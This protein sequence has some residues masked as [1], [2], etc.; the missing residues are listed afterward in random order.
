MLVRFRFGI[1]TRVYHVND[2][3][4]HV[5]PGIMFNHRQS[6]RQSISIDPHDP[7][8]VDPNNELSSPVCPCPPTIA[9][10]NLR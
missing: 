4:N 7:I 9:E 10:A 2:S 3:V 8:S 1:S 5:R 6:N